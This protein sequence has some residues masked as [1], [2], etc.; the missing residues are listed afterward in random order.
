[1]LFLESELVLCT[2]STTSVHKE[3]MGWANPVSDL[4]KKFLQCVTNLSFR[5]VDNPTNWCSSCVVT[6]SSVDDAMRYQNVATIVANYQTC[7]LIDRWK[8]SRRIL[9]TRKYPLESKRRFKK[10]AGMN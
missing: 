9:E 3:H 8:R 2:V 10:R 6:Q 1:M 5:T 4:V 7:I